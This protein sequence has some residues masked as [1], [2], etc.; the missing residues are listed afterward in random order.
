MNNKENIPSNKILL[1]KKVSNNIPNKSQKLG[2][3]T[4][5]LLENLK[6]NK[7]SILDKNKIDV[8]ELSE[9]DFHIKELEKNQFNLKDSKKISIISKKISSK[10]NSLCAA[11]FEKKVDVNLLNWNEKNIYNIRPSSSHFFYLIFEKVNIILKNLLKKKINIKSLLNHLDKRVEPWVLS[12]FPNRKLSYD[13]KIK[14]ILLLMIAIESKKFQD[15]LF[16]LNSASYRY[17]LDYPNTLEPIF[18]SRINLN[19][20]QLDKI[21]KFSVDPNV[22]VSNLEGNLIDVR[23]G[24][25]IYSSISSNTNVLKDINIGIK[26]GEFILLLGPSGSGKTTLMNCLSGIDQLSFGDIVF[27][28]TNI[29]KLTDHSLTKFRMQAIAYVFQHYG[30]LP[31]LNVEENILIGDFLKNK[32]YTWKTR[33]DNHQR[34][35]E[36][37]ETLIKD[38][39]IANEKHKMPYELSGGQQQRVAIARAIA[40]RP[41]ALFADEPTSSLDEKTG[42]IVL[43]FLKEANIK[44]GQTIIMITHN[45]KNID[46]ASRIIRLKDGRIIED[47][48]KE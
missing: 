27:D 37:I 22:L 3:H 7:K 29:T 44:Y 16:L 1:D 15:Y 23:N 41:K 14:K 32:N 17:I 11:W 34:D 35:E 24:Y 30:L 46:Y 48:K 43:N 10:I 13:L 31:N 19:I 38:F 4:K 2:G 8:K 21:I 9:L 42:E 28:N 6:T 20:F 33:I 5:R 40:K 45:E 26:P 18:E 39:G 12:K 36:F 47:R 25:K